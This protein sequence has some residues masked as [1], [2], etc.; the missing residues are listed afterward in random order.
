MN[1]RPIIHKVVYRWG[2]VADPTNWQ[3]L[4]TMVLERA[5]LSDEVVDA[6]FDNDLLAAG[7]VYGTPDAGEPVEISSLQMTHEHGVTEV[8]VYNLGIMLFHTDDEVYRRVLR[9]CSVIG[10]QTE[11]QLLE[12]SHI[13]RDFPKTLTEPVEQARPRQVQESQQAL[14]QLKVVLLETDPPIWRRFVVPSS[15]TLHRLHL[16]L[17]DVMGWTNSHLYRFRIGG[18]EYAEPDPDNEF[19]EL[20]FKNSRRTKLGQLVTKKGDVLLY[21]YDFGDSW[22]HMLLVEDILEYEFD[23]RYPICLTGERACPPEDCGGTH[24][25]AE[26]LEIIRGPDHEEYLDMMSWLGGQFDPNMFDIR[27]VNRKLHSM[28]LR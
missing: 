19:N 20:D 14:Y 3:G 9:V 27:A 23:N 13:D 25:Y 17:Q 11:R 7:G 18:K 8:T 28:R 15:V 10:K 22:N 6:I 5:E 24:G 1:T 12:N 4:K 26:L 2:M 21:E 16:I